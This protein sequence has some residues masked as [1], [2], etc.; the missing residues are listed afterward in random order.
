MEQ[1]TEKPADLHVLQT[2]LWITIIRGLQFL[3]A[4]IILALAGRLIHDAY[5]DE[6]GLALAVVCS[7]KLPFSV[8][9]D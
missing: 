8:R 6:E 2:P 1:H 9:L 7:T 4:L 5:L 3:L